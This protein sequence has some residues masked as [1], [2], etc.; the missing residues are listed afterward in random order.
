M[1]TNNPVDVKIRLQIAS[2]DVYLFG[3][4]FGVR[5]AFKG[6]IRSILVRICDQ[7]YL[8]LI[9][10]ESRAQGDHEGLNILLQNFLISSRFNQKLGLQRKNIDFY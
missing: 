6:R 7:S 2:I 1:H 4:F 9:G 8:N 10:I 3:F 5:S